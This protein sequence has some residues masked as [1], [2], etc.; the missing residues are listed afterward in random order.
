MWRFRV[1]KTVS[2]KGKIREILNKKKIIKKGNIR[3][4]LSLKRQTKKKYGENSEPKKKKIGKGCIKR[5]KN[6]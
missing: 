4:I 1:K 3:K 6:V 5:T 2:K